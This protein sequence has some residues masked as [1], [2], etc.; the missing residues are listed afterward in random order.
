M[1]YFY[2]RARD[3]RSCETRLEHDGPGFELIIIDG[4][5]SWVERFDDVRALHTR[6]YELRH[7]WQ[8]NG[9]RTMGEDTELDEGE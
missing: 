2:Q 3:M 5:E 9:W 1:I 7:A 8:L 4:R 6:E